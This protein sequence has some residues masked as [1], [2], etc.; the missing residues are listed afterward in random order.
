[1]PVF[2]VHSFSAAIDGSA[3]FGGGDGAWAGDTAASLCADAGNQPAC[4][5]RIAFGDSAEAAA[6]ILEH[7]V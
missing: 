4:L 1:V 2:S 3:S 5:R 7:A 6:G